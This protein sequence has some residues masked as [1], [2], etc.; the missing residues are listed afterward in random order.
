MRA[1]IAG[2][3]EIAYQF[4]GELAERRDT[5][6]IAENPDFVPNRNF[7]RDWVNVVVGVIWQTSLVAL[8]IFFVLMKWGAVAI[9]LSLT[10]VTMVFL[11]KNWYDKLE[12][13]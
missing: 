1:I 7:S 9:T 6:V 4:A 13:D 2:S 12:A 3:G 8:P 10:L 5:V 11:K